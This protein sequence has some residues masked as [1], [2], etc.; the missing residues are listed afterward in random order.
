MGTRN[1]YASSLRKGQ[2]QKRIEKSTQEK[3][4][5]RD[6]NDRKA[7]HK[8]RHF[9]DDGSHWQL[10]DNVEYEGKEGIIK[11]PRGPEG[12]LGVAVDG[13]YML[14]H[15]DDDKLKLKKIDESLQLM[16]DLSK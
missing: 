12:L 5:Q 15:S 14:I 8:G 2:Y 16:R 3:Q 4:R 13:E 9:N 7:K 6:S 11:Q 10:G 1:P